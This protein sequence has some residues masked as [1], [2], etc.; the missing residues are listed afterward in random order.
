MI[1]QALIRA[2][3]SHDVWFDNEQGRPALLLDEVPVFLPKARRD[4]ECPLSL[5]RETRDAVA[6]FKAAVIADLKPAMPPGVSER[7]IR[8][9]ERLLSSEGSTLNHKQVETTGAL[10]LVWMLQEIEEARQR[11]PLSHLEASFQGWLEK[12]V[13]RE[14]AIIVTERQAKNELE[15]EAGHEVTTRALRRLALAAGFRRVH[16]RRARLFIRP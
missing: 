6:A 4:G 9:Y 3:Q 14:G 15:D 16:A 11:P 2:A 5:R 13:A 7:H 8:H 10:S 12:Q 1:R